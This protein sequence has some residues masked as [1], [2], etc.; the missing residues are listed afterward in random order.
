MNEPSTGGDS[1]GTAEAKPKSAAGDLED[2]LDFL[3][4]STE[5]KQA[6]TIGDLIEALD[7]RSFGPLLL[8]PALISISPIGM[9]PGA[10]VVTGTLIILIAVQMLFS[11]GTLWI[12][13]RLRDF[14]FSR[15]KLEKGA[16]QARR[17]LKPVDRLLRPRWT[18][19][20]D[21]PFIYPLAMLCILLALSF[22]P[23]ALV[24]FGV[25]LPGAA[26]TLFALGLTARD[27][28][29]I[30]TGLTGTAAAG[31]LVWNYWPF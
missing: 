24:P 18:W 3:L 6:V 1:S 22:Y 27:G 26:V 5:G 23:L 10:S 28:I 15:E 14:S 20:A 17:W 12:P 8:V 9:I 31:W 2:L 11:S 4:E 13:S 16:N 29:L 25:L 21:A 19:F 30:A 7:S